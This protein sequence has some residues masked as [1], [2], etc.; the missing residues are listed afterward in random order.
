MK[1]TVLV[2]IALVIGLALT[3]AAV[4]SAEA[5]SIESRTSWVDYA[6]KGRDDFYDKDVVAYKEGSKAVLAVEVKNH[7]GSYINVTVVGVSFDW[8]K[9]AGGWYNSTQASKTSPLRLEDGETRFMVINFTVPGLSTTYPLVH[10]YTVYVEFVKSD[11][12]SDKWT[13]TRAALFDA[14]KQYFV[15]FSLEQAQASQRAQ[16]I[17][18]IKDS[19]GIPVAWSSAKAGLL[20]KK[21]MNE[22]SLADYYYNLGDFASANTH[23]M[24]ALSLIDLAFDAEETR[25]VRL[26]DAQ[27]KKAEAEATYFDSLGS[28]FSGL[29]SMWTLFGVALVLFAIGYIIKGLAALRKAAAPSPQ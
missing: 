13:K 23:Y 1:K 24:M 3:L 11:G 5:G 6:F 21:A 28:F 19:L 8:Q 26:E 18:G 22:T 29:S 15:V 14:D 10:D 9:P 25:G 20:W 12:T 16:A 2:A 4:N 17:E 7:L 27:I